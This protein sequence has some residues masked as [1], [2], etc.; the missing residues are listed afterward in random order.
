MILITDVTGRILELAKP[1]SRV[2]SLIPSITETLFE[3][4]AGD[5]V[6]GVSKYCVYPAAGVKNKIRVGGQKN[7]D[8]ERIKRLDPDLIIL[9]VEENKPGD[10]ERLS[11]EYQTYVTYPRR[12]ADTEKLLLDLGRIFNVEAKAEE[13]ANRIRRPLNAQGFRAGPQLKA[14]YLIWRRPWMSIN[15]DTFIHDVMELHNLTN[16]FADRA[17]R[18]FEVTEKDIEAADPDVIILPDEPYHF[19]EKHKAELASIPRSTVKK[20]RIILADGT[21][22]CWYGTRTARASHYIRALIAEKLSD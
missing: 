15:S 9:N 7:P 2:I 17:E 16:V 5:S 12:W 6:A 10:I 4:G 14:L 21:Y 3:L 19:L 22:F 8:F 20:R 1:P 18:Y 11:R 13:Y